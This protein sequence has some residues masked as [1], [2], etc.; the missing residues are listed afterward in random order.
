MYK[1]D[2]SDTDKLPPIY[3][4][5]R[6]AIAR[7]GYN[8]IVNIF[9]IYDS[10]FI[11]LIPLDICYTQDTYGVWL[12]I[13]VNSWYVISLGSSNCSPEHEF[14]IYCRFLLVYYYIINVIKLK[15]VYNSI[16]KLDFTSHQRT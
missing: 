16:F 15:K 5:P 13:L 1:F 4:S 14:P 10:A 11:L 3:E 12:I 8:G 2:H 6:D 9:M 7:I